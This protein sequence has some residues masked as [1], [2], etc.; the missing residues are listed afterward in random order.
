MMEVAAGTAM[1]IQGY[2][3][4]DSDERVGFL[5]VLCYEGDILQTHLSE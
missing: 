5:F 2:K 4:S 3:K 1:I